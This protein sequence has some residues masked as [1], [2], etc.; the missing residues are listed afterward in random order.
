MI[1]SEL[2]RNIVNLILFQVGWLYCAIATNLSA[3]IVAMVLVAVHLLL[4]SQHRRQEA[5]FIATGTALGSLLDG[6]NLNTGVLAHP[7]QPVWT[8][9]WLVGLWAL[10]LTTLHHS[11]AWVGKKRWLLFTLAPIGGPFSYWSATRLGATSFPDPPVSL[12]ALAA[13]W[14]IVLPLLFMLK[15]RIMPE[16]SAL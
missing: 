7:A 2:G 13:G 12:L 3:G 16:T 6:L 4:V 9:F 5:L 11:L 10:F 1:N 8:P 15:R 14:V